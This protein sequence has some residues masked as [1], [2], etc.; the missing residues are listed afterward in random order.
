MLLSEIYSNVAALVYGDITASPPPTHEVVTMQ[1]LILAKHRECQV[2][3]NY[4][5]QK[6]IDT[7]DIVSGTGSY[8]WPDDFKEL[9]SFDTTGYELTATG[10]KLSAV[11][12]AAVTSNITY[13]SIL[14]TPATWDGTH[15]DA[16]T[17]YLA[18]YLIYSVTGSMMLK[19]SEQSEAGAYLQLAE[20]A[21]FRAEQE[22]YQR[23]QSQSEIW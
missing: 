9:I 10:F 15:T 16:V 21:R 12:T 4:W 22:D 14:E 11:P 19:R 1:T 23:R 2:G 18:W 3:F 17:V 7:F 8:D 5:F 6:V 20:Q 13:W